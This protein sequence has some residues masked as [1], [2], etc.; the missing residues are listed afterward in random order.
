MWGGYPCI[1]TPWPWATGRLGVG[2]AAGDDAEGVRGRE[3]GRE[4]RGGQGGGG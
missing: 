2:T 4:R 1:A 3:A